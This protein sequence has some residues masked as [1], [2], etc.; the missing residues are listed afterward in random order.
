[1]QTA[2]SEHEG[3]C[4]Q[5]LNGCRHISHDT[6]CSQGILH[7]VQAQ[8][9]VCTEWCSR[10]AVVT[11]GCCLTPGRARHGGSLSIQGLSMPRKT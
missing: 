8:R 7:D 11:A 9:H 10:I 4:T 3:I 6:D 1:M 5:A 2:K